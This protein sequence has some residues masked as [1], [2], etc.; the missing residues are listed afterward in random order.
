MRHCRVLENLS[1]TKFTQADKL[2][3]TN[4]ECDT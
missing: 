1:D 3:D 2:K 4:N